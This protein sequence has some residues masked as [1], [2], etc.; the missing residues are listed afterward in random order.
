MKAIILGATGTAGGSVLKTCLSNP[1]VKE[2]RAIT[3]RPLSITGDKLR[4]FLHK[5]FLDYTTISEAFADVDAC[6]YCLGKSVTQVSGEQEY[7]TITHAFALAAA[8]MLKTQSPRAVFHFISGQ[9][10]RLDSRFMWA[11]VKAETEEELLLLGNAVCW[12]PGF[13]DGELSGSSPSLYRIFHPLA[14]LLKPFHSIY[15]K[16]ED[17]GKAMLQATTENIRSRIIENKEIHSIAARCK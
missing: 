6:F 2:L 16:G 10:T 13:I 17:I 14:K 12:R 1:F 7:R 8:Q 11:H 15:I 9:G 3:R 5:N 4:I